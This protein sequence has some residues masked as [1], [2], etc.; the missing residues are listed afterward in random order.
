MS[1]KMWSH[2]GICPTM[3]R[4]ADGEVSAHFGGDSSPRGRCTSSSWSGVGP[5]SWRHFNFKIRNIRWSITQISNLYGKVLKENKSCLETKKYNSTFPC[6][7]VSG[8]QCIDSR[9]YCAL[10]SSF[11]Q[12]VTLL[13]G[14]S[15]SHCKKLRNCDAC[16]LVENHHEIDVLIRKSNQNSV[17]ITYTENSVIWASSIVPYVT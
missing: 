5:R 9:F 3:G 4:E 15:D 17:F 14:I 16:L 2:C 12:N 7:H 11:F 13:S 8:L 6:F 1:G 10:S